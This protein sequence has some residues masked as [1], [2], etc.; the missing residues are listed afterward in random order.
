MANDRVS[1]WNQYLK[2]FREPASG[3]LMYGNGT[4]FT[5][6]SISEVI[7]AAFPSA[8]QGS[9]LYR[10][11][12]DWTYLGPGTAGQLLQTGG[13]G[14]NPSWATG[15]SPPAIANNTIVS[16]VSGSSAA[17][18]ANTLTQVLDA[19]AGNTQGSILYRSATDWTVLGPGTNGQVLKT[20]GSGANPF[21]G[22]TTGTYTLLTTVTPSTATTDIFFTTSARIV[23]YYSALNV[24]GT[25]VNSAVLAKFT[26]TG[27]AIWYPWTIQIYLGYGTNFATGNVSIVTDSSGTVATTV[28]ANGYNYDGTRPQYST[29]FTGTGFA[30]G[31]Y[32]NGMQI[33]TSSGATFGGGTIYVYSVT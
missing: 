4:D 21:W 9:I 29:V 7:N 33:T 6:G 26:A 13:T 8:P 32:I 5:L 14:A 30:A 12:T 15:Y 25:A 17:P 27:G 1:I 19:V 2:I 28:T 18:S 11:A 23:I 22:S 20:A 10:N 24:N 16:N 31:T 3:E